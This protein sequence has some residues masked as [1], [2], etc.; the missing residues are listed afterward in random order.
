MASFQL[1]QYEKAKW[2]EIV[3]AIPACV[4]IGE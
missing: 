1:L 4:S 2:P 3:D